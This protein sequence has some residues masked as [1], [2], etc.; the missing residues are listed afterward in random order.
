MQ[1]AWLATFLF[2]TWAACNSD[3]L[4]VAEDL[5]S[6]SLLQQSLSLQSGNVGRQRNRLELETHLQAGGRGLEKTRQDDGELDVTETNNFLHR[7]YSRSHVDSSFM[8]GVRTVKQKLRV[9]PGGDAWHR[10]AS[11]YTVV[12]YNKTEPAKPQTI[13]KEY[14]QQ[15]VI[16]VKNTTG[17]TN[18]LPPKNSSEVEAVTWTQPAPFVNV[19]TNTSV[20]KVN[21]T[22]SALTEEIDVRIASPRDI[23][24]AHLAAFVPLFSAW[25]IHLFNGEPRWLYLLL[26]PLTLCYC[27]VA[28]HLVNQTLEII[29]GSPLGVTAVQSLM[30]V[31]FTGAWFISKDQD[32]ISQ[33]G[34]LRQYGSW[35]SVAVLF[36]VYQ[37]FNHLVSFHCTL[38]E[39]TLFNNLCPVVTFILEA[40]AMPQTLKPKTSL[41]VKVSMIAM[42]VG[43]VVFSCQSEAFTAEGVSSASLMV[44]TVV[45]YRIT[46]RCF[47]STGRFQSLA[48]LSCIDGSICFLA[49]TLPMLTGDM[50]FIR[51]IDV[52]VTNRSILALLLVSSLTFTSQHVVSLAM[53]RIGSATAY[54]VFMSLAGFIEVA[55]GIIYF[56]DDVFSSRLSCMGLGISLA[57]GL[58]YSTEV[59]RQPQL[60]PADTDEKILG[61]PS[62]RSTFKKQTSASAPDLKGLEK[63]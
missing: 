49:A 3:W 41:G 62:S 9:L 40:V 18:R 22:D 54:L 6:T 29:T 48:F 27:L 33:E 21:K 25:C 35:V 17:P 43:A 11:L 37:L 20:Q 26:L 59:T 31:V 42:V 15:H 4:G 63:D 55:L 45:A 13:H 34:G 44:F 16:I 53:L 5:D 10:G 32:V 57:S 61:E 8:A 28:Q 56:G 2:T 36:S 50:A 46:Q 39:R 60:D 30:M 1:F 23:L 14:N 52:W 19:S 7:L 58:W 24:I 38:S 47:L 51:N 12:I